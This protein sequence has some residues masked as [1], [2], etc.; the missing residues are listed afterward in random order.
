LKAER[1][2]LSEIQSFYQKF[3][4]ILSKFIQVSILQEFKSP[5]SCI[6]HQGLESLAV[7]S[8]KHLNH[9][10]Q[11]TFTRHCPSMDIIPN[12][13]ESSWIELYPKHF[14][15]LTTSDDGSHGVSGVT[16]SPGVGPRQIRLGQVS[17]LKVSTQDVD[18][19]EIYWN[20]ELPSLDIY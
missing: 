15:R 16:F 5:G 19:T 17:R 13:S 20:A 3:Y 2:N 1:K 7:M 12:H 10:K 8:L 11:Q 4:Q 6:L 18:A 9:L 14:V